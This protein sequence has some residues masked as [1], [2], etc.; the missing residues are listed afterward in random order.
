M[1]IKDALTRFFRNSNDR[2]NKNDEVNLSFGA[3][4]GKDVVKMS[5][6]EFKSKCEKEREKLVKNISSLSTEQ[7]KNELDQMLKALEIFSDMRMAQ[8]LAGNLTVKYNLM[9]DCITK[10]RDELRKKI[11]DS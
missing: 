11:Q 2:K 3:I 8:H 6:D 1:T 10:Y 9:R 4:T 5:V 7:R